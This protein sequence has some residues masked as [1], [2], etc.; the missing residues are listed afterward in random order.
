MDYTLDSAPLCIDKT[1]DVAQVLKLRFQILNLDNKPTA[2]PS[3]ELLVV[4][5]ATGELVI[6]DIR[7]GPHIDRMTRPNRPINSRPHHVGHKH[8]HM[9]GHTGHVHRHRH[10]H[11]FWTMLLAHVVV[12]LLVFGVPAGATLFLIVHRIR[13]A[14]RARYAQLAKE[15]QDVEGEVVG[16]KKMDGYVP[17]DVEAQ[18]ELPVYSEK[19]AVIEE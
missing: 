3:L 17:V 12:P 4:E 6:G 14:K 15:E 13:Q 5:L 9:G 10:F 11:N 7:T 8:G 18:E 2:L 19:E 16:S 1:P